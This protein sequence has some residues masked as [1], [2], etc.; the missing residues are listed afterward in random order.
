VYK[1]ELDG[2]ALLSTVEVY[3]VYDAGSLTLPL[4]GASHGILVI[5]LL[6]AKV[7][8]RKTD[9]PAA[10]DIY[11]RVNGEVQRSR[12]QRRKFW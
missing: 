11:R 4:E 5:L 2:T 8:L 6:A 7:T 3:D 1:V 9:T 10:A 12:A